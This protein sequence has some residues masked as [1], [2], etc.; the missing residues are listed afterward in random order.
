MVS[1]ATLLHQLPIVLLLLWYLL[2]ALPEVLRCHLV[3][4]SL[5][6]QRACWVNPRVSVRKNH[7]QTLPDGRA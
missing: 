5:Q 7:W 4:L 1:V 3:V 2:L 6:P